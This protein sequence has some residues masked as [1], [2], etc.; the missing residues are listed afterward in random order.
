MSVESDLK[1]IARHVRRFTPRAGVDREAIV[2]DIWMELY[3]KKLPILVKHIKYRCID[4]IR[5]TKRRK[6][7][8]NTFRKLINRTFSRS[9]WDRLDIDAIISHAQ[10]T[11]IEKKFIFQYFWKGR[12]LAEIAKQLGLA[13]YAT[14]KIKGIIINKLQRSARYLERKDS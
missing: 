11:G 8:E 5:K 12:S 13:K 7:S 3:V 10:L 4:E 14:P 2:H 6:D 1:E 9:S